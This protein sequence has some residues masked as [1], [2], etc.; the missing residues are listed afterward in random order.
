MPCRLRMSLSDISIWFLTSPEMLISALDHWRERNRH[1]PACRT[2]WCSGKSMCEYVTLISSYENIRP[3]TV[4]IWN[5][6]SKELLTVLLMW[7]PYEPSRQRELKQHCRSLQLTSWCGN[8]AQSPEWF[9][10]LNVQLEI[11]HKLSKCECLINSF[12]ALQC[13][14]NIYSISVRTEMMPGVKVC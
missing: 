11:S 10:L 7:A 9:F 2:P 14:I 3:C 8:L 13:D 1:R 12:L 6:W 4:S 5:K